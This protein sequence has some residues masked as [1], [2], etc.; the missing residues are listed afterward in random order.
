M[1]TQVQSLASLSR[2]RIRHFCELWCKSKMQ[3]RFHVAVAVV[4]AGSYSS[5]STP[6]LGT[7]CLGCAPKKTKKEKK[8]YTGID[9]VLAC[10]L[11]AFFPPF[12]ICFIEEW[13]IC[14]PT[15]YGGSQA[16]SGIRAGTIS[17]LKVY[18]HRRWQGSQKRQKDQKKKKRRKS[19]H[20]DRPCNSMFP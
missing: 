10:S 6:S 16:R 20:G 2:L 18:R 1:R 19:I 14:T 8:V 11:N 17:F 3:L 13:L 5:N 7:S 4:Q 9:Y 12:F 15:A